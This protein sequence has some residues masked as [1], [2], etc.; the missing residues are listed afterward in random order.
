MMTTLDIYSGTALSDRDADRLHAPV[1][2]GSPTTPPASSARSEYVRV[3]LP[4]GPALRP[5]CPMLVVGGNGGSGAT[6][7]AIGITSA[8]TQVEGSG[9]PVVVDATPAG[10]DLARRGADEHRCLSSVQAWLASI[11]PSLPSPVE[12]ACGFSSLGIGVLGRTEN[13][14][15]RRETFA[16]VHRLL[17]DA[18]VAAVYDGGAPLQA[19]GIRPLLADPRVPVVVTV[20]ARA[21]AANR[22]MPALEWLD[23]HCTEFVVA[24]CAVVVTHQSVHAHRGVS[25]H[26]RTHLGQWVR[27]VFDIPYDPH[28]AL[29]GPI[30]WAQLNPLTR[31]AYRNLMQEMQK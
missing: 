20:A 1:P 19:N 11:E 12:D 6:T 29:G 3:G 16:S 4:D 14:L 27:G 23:E 18:G 9:W 10:G 24:D 21:D 5:R 28:L 22:L 31:T 25:E 7:T 13:H 26:L 15:P 30:T 17:G 2:P 8:L